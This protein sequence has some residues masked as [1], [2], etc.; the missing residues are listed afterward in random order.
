MQRPSHI[1]PRVPILHQPV[2]LL[3]EDEFLFR[4]ME[5]DV[6]REAGFWVLEA[7]DADEA[8]RCL[9][10]RDD[11]KAI[12]TDVAMPGSLNGF[13]F[14]RLVSQ[15]WPEVRV[16]VV[17]GKQPPAAGELPST[18]EFVAKPVSPKALVNKVRAM[19]GGSNIEHQEQLRALTGGQPNSSAHPAP[20][21]GN[22]SAGQG[23]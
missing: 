16:L 19:L 22:D 15:G 21:T 11:I 13:E 4:A 23:L 8:F 10:K 14:A 17:S 12:I 7:E 3:V 20:S 18:A 2:I 5:V 9:K 1:K 6:L